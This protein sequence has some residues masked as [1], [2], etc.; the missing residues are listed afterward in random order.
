MSKKEAKAK[1]TKAKTTSSMK[2]RAV[3][4]TKSI[5][6]KILFVLVLGMSLI[7]VISLITA[8]PRIRASSEDMVKGYMLDSVQAN[9]SNIEMR[10]KLIDKDLLASKKELAETV[11]KIRIKG[12]DNSYA[13]IVAKDGTMLYHPNPDKIGQPVENEVVKKLVEDMQVGIADHARVVSYQYNGSTKYAAFYIDTYM[14]FVLVISADEADVFKNAN[15]ITRNLIVMSLITLAILLIVAIY[16]INRAINPLNDLA[17]IANK[18]ADLDFT[19]NP[20]QDKLNKRSDE[21]GLVSK[22]ITKL[23]GQLSQIIAEIQSQGQKLADSNIEFNKEFGEIVDGINN[24][25]NAVDEI[26]QGSTSQAQETTSASHSVN[27]IGLAIESNT[28]SVDSLEDSIKSMNE[29]AENSNKMLNELI[30]I[31]NKT[32]ENIR[33]V[34]DQINVTNESSEQIKTA[35]S[36][37][38]DIADQTS[39]LSLNASIEAARAGEQG[40]GFAVVAEEIRKLADDS[41]ARAAEIDSI[42]EEVIHNSKGSVE[43]VT[44]LT[45]EA[46]VQRDKIEDTRESFNGLQ[47]EIQIVSDAAKDIFEQTSTISS[48]KGNVSDVIEQLAAIAEQNA[49]SSQETSSSMNLLTANIDKCKEE[50]ENLSELSKLLSE[51]TSKFKF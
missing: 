22:G 27:D 46:I 49:A 31:N 44:E 34:L 40:K 16:L 47:S 30:E 43:K 15:T 1:K 21:I 23:H 6:S 38:Q 4:F 2:T 37:I 12:V 51:Q 25:N 20:N 19:E 17:F 9:G 8:V 36:Y 24:I 3:P 32:T 5:K 45:E 42:A 39:L 29:L 10:Y 28:S 14:E 13:Y 18:V 48:L 50:T 35:V 33:I 26:S 11:S 41:A 7:T